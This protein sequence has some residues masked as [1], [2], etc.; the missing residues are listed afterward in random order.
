MAILQLGCNLQSHLKLSCSRKNTL[1][2]HLGY[3]EIF[4]GEFCE[5][6]V[7]SVK[8]DLVALPKAAGFLH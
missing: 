5:S 3:L 8:K 7:A 4:I 2:W 1:T 6:T